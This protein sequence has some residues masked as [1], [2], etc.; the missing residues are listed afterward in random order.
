MVTQANKVRQN[1]EL[2]LATPA[3]FPSIREV[4]RLSRKGALSHFM[5]E[6]EIE[7]EVQQYYNDDVL[8]GILSNPANAIFVV[9]DGDQ[10]LGH[11]S[12]LPKDRR[13]KPRLLQFYVR[14][15]TQRAGIGEMLFDR[16]RQWLTDAEASD[17]YISTL[18]DN[19][20]GRSFLEKHNCRLL[21]VYDQTW[22]GK[23]HSIALYYLPL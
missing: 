16:A 9:V 22:D 7:D 20:V 18:G 4:A 13:G 3:D 1:L 10:T 23:T 21:Q 2:R 19:N 5:T 11:C 12:V 14:P 6:D 8:N 15:D 17:M